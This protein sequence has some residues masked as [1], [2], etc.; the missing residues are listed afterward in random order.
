MSLI[1]NAKRRKG[2]GVFW[3]YAPPSDDG[4]AGFRCSEP[5]PPRWPAR[6]ATAIR[7]R[8]AIA[9]KN[10][11]ETLWSPSG[12]AFGLA[13]LLALLALNF[14][15]LDG[16]QREHAAEWPW[17]AALLLSL[18]ALTSAVVS[19]KRE[20]RE[21]ILSRYKHDLEA[22]AVVCNAAGCFLGD[23]HR[24]SPAAEN[25]KMVATRLRLLVEE[26][27]PNSV[28]THSMGPQ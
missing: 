24:S 12:R 20:T 17:G 19:G 25:A 5:E 21:Q 27:H 26:L 13:I 16:W 3:R 7:A 28:G 14:A 15:E 9:R 22:A 10:L 23:P 6:L 2:A 11:R 8:L 1:L 4:C 18:A